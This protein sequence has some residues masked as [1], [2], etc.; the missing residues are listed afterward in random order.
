MSFAEIHSGIQKKNNDD[1]DGEERW[2]KRGCVFAH[3]PNLT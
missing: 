2:S 1:D 3:D